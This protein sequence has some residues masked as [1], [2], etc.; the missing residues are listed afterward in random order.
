MPKRWI[1]VNLADPTDAE[2]A[3]MVNEVKAVLRESGQQGSVQQ[4]NG[5]G[6]D[7]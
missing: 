2:Y 4:D 7:A 5:K 6:D 1:K 3:E